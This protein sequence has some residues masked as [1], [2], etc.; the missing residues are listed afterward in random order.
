MIRKHYL[1]KLKISVEHL[2]NDSNKQNE[3]IDHKIGTIFQA[4]GKFSN[5]SLFVLSV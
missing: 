2:K 5:R 1:F 3:Q 4:K